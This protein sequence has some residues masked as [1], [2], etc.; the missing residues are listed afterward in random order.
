MRTAEPWPLSAVAVI[1]SISGGTLV[2]WLLMMVLT[3]AAAIISNLLL[4]WPALP[5]A[6]TPGTGYDAFRACAHLKF[7]GLERLST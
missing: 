5:L 3:S 1:A 4:G 2:M 6:S 7:F